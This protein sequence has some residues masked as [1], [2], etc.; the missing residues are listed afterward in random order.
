MAYLDGIGNG[1]SAFVQELRAE[2]EAC[3]SEAR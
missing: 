3:F 1:E 2:A